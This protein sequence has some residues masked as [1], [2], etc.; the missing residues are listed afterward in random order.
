LNEGNLAI[1]ADLVNDIEHVKGVIENAG[2]ASSPELSQVQTLLE[3]ATASKEIG[4]ENK[5]QE[6][7][8]Q[9]KALLGMK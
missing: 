4:D 6:Y 9:A 5:A 1:A 7:I 2:G 8:D 3:Q